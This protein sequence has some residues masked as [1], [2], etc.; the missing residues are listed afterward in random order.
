LLYELKLDDK[1]S[2]VAALLGVVG[3]SLAASFNPAQ[4]ASS[5]DPAQALLEQMSETPRSPCASPK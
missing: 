1:L 2:M 4:R 5:T 3:V